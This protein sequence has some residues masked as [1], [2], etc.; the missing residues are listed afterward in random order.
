MGEAL[1]PIQETVDLVRFTEE[2]FNGKLLFLC[3][4]AFTKN[5]ENQTNNCLKMLGEKPSKHSILDVRQGSDTTRKLEFQFLQ[6]YGNKYF[7]TLDGGSC[8]II[9]NKILPN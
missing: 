8:F 9:I 4:E 5:N 6:I 7:P 1:F 3:S 2:F